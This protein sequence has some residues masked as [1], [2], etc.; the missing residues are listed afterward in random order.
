MLPSMQQTLY[1]FRGLPGSGKSTYARKLAAELG[2]SDHYEADMFFE[3]DGTYTFD[4]KKIQEAHAWCQQKTQTALEAGRSVVVANTFTQK[5][6]MEF[7]FNLANRL[8]I[9]V[10]IQTCEGNYQNVHG[11]PQEIIEKMRKRFEQI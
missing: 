5:W 3:K 8:G 9:P 1:I 2:I 7:Y 10:E 6:E 4:R 11:V